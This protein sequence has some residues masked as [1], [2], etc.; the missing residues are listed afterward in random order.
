VAYGP[1]CRADLPSDNP[2]IAYHEI[3]AIHIFHDFAQRSLGLHHRPYKYHPIDACRFTSACVEPPNYTVIC[4]FIDFFK[5]HDLFANEE[6]YLRRTDLFK[7]TD[8]QE[9]LPSDQYV[10]AVRGLHRFDLHDEVALNNA[11]AF[12]RQVSEG[13]FINCWQLFEGET[14]AMLGRYGK[15]VVIFSRYE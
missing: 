12:S 14:L 13:R 1:V 11:Q 6:I 15:G 3:A 10:R 2:H 7:E 4:R 8:P 9:G 5:F